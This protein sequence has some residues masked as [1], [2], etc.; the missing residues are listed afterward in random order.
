MTHK[1]IKCSTEYQDEDTEAYLCAPCVEAK[2]AIAAEIDARFTQNRAP[3][4]TE[5]QRFD[6]LPKYQGKYVNAR[7]LFI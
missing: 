7:D 3:V 1:C 4:L 6:S 2:K 5:L